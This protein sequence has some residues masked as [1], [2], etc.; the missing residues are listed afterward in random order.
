MQ[1]TFRCIAVQAWC[2]GCSVIMHAGFPT[3]FLK[4]HDSVLQYE[5]VYT[6]WSQT[7]SVG[8]SGTDTVRTT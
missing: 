6:T 3:G 4:S 2:S 8:S 1:A 7:V 5:P